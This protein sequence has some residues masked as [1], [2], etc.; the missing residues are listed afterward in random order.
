VS[1]YIKLYSRE[2]RV[3]FLHIEPEKIAFDACASLVVDPSTSLSFLKNPK[4]NARFAFIFK[5]TNY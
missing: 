1:I 3:Y 2:N 4:D 5:T